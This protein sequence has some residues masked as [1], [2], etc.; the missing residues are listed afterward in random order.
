MNQYLSIFENIFN[1][2]NIDLN[3]IIKVIVSE[4]WIEN[5]YDLSEL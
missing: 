2:L 1:C 4:Q 3:Q 5:I